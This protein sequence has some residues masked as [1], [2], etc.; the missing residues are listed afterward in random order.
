MVWVL[1][2]V[3]ATSIFEF[4]ASK[5]MAQINPH[6]SL[7]IIVMIACLALPL[8]NRLTGPRANGYTGM[9]SRFPLTDNTNL[10]IR[11]SLIHWEIFAVMRAYSSLQRG[12]GVYI[13]NGIGQE[14]GPQKERHR[15]GVV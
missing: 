2:R 15:Q 9:D 7:A 4:S 10:T 13:T 1:I 11:S 12:L 14:S 5:A 6:S 8:A 3:Y